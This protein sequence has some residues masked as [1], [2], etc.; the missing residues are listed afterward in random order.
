[1]TDEEEHKRK[2]LIISLNKTKSHIEKM[3]SI[4]SKEERGGRG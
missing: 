1:M 4:L 2:Q 3:I